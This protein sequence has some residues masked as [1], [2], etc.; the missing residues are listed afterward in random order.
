MCSLEKATERDFEYAVENSD[1]ETAARYLV[2]Q[3]LIGIDDDKANANDAIRAT[4]EAIEL[5]IVDDGVFGFNAASIAI[6]SS[7]LRKLRATQEKMKE[8]A[9]VEPFDFIDQEWK[10]EELL[11]DNHDVL[12]QY[13]NIDEV[14][15]E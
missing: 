14:Y 13:E 8:E 15:D 4:R 9:D 1:Y 3:K 10:D 11:Y 5:L 12:E 2:E 6:V 7:G